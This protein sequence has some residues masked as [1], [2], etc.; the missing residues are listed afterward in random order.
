MLDS[1]MTALAAAGGLAVARAA[2]TDA[3]AGIRQA[4]ARWFGRGD[5]ERER[6]ELARLDQTAVALTVAAGGGEG[7]LRARIEEETSWR[8]RFEVVLESLDDA[9]RREAVAQLQALI[10]GRAVP[11]VGQIS[12]SGPGATSVVGTYESHGT[13]VNI[14]K[15]YG[16]MWPGSPLPGGP[17][18][19]GPVPGG[20]APGGPTPPAPSQG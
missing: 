5:E 9:R 8:T 15:M 10:E 6:A 18:P 2:G 16:G 1:T 13:T 14:E 11:G 12:V 7:A 19:G 4:V 20:A 17:V 3:W